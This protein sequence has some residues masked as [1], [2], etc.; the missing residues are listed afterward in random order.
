MLK[1]SVS[2]LYISQS[3]LECGLG[4]LRIA[5]LVGLRCSE[6]RQAEQARR[7]E[8]FGRSDGGRRVGRRR[9][10]IAYGELQ[11]RQF[12]VRLHQLLDSARAVQ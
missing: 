2:S 11:T 9:S 4:L 7:P 12:D 10:S 8:P 5:L 1:W 3:V 6:M